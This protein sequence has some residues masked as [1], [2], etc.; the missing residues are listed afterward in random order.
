MTSSAERVLVLTPTGRDGQMVCG[1]IVADGM[2]CEVCAD[3]PA[4][5]AGIASGAAAAVV[6][7]EALSPRGAEM[8]LAALE[9]QE[10]WSDIPVLLLAEARSRAPRVSTRFFERA[11]VVLLPRPLA[12]QLLLSSVRSAVRARRRQYQMRDL[13]RELE[14]AVQL[15]DMFVSILGHDLRTPLGAIRL[16]A[17]A[18]VRS[19]P[20]ARALRPAGRIL[21]SADRMKRLIEQLLDYARARQGQGMPL[22]LGR[23]HLGELCRQA[24]QELEDAN[25]QASL[26]L[27][28]A[29][30]LSG[31]WDADRLAQVVS[32][33]V[34]NAVQHGAK[35][36]PITVDVDGTD[37]STVRLRVQNVGAVPSEVLP[38]LFEP[39][40]RM[41]AHATSAAGRTGLGLG[42]FI[43]REIAQA[44]G[45]DVRVQSSGSAPPSRSRYRATL[46][47]PTLPGSA[48]PD[49]SRADGHQ[50]KRALDRLARRPRRP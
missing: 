13:L 17:E 34:G 26:V 5:L 12:I 46:D 35:G 20:D 37:E 47:A 22:H 41:A 8:L 40:K 30:D 50:R 24:V 14:R 27:Q 16:A 44:H 3:L 21:T 43:A 4:L 31:T 48:R 10:P 32:N 49:G 19:T 18:I 28:D 7:Q 1:R 11:N 45:G 33:L 36:K 38:T 6:A 25:P 2:P 23:V 15:S 42:L 9:A 39:F 29:G